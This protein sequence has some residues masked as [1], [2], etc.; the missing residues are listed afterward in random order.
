M[1]TTTRTM[2]ERHNKLSRGGAWDLYKGRGADTPPAR[3][4]D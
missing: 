2:R 1:T 4:R 3:Q